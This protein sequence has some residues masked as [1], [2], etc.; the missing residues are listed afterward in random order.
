MMST[1]YN[2]T[3]STTTTYK[4]SK[5]LSTS[6]TTTMYNG[7]GTTHKIRQQLNFTDE[8][9]WKQFSSRRLELIDKFGLSE[10]KASE[11]DDNIR[12]IANMLREE[13]NYP[14]TAINEFEK[15]VTA[16]V[17]SVRRNRKRSKKRYES[18]MSNKMTKIDSG[19]SSS[20]SNSSSNSSSTASSPIQHKNVELYTSTN[21]L[22]LPSTSTSHHPLQLQQKQQH[23]TGLRSPLLS[24]HTQH[25]NNKIVSLPVATSTT[26]KNI[27]PHM[28]TPPPTITSSSA[29]SSTSTSANNT[30]SLLPPVQDQYIM[31]IRSLC[32]DLI[33]IKL[34]SINKFNTTINVNNKV[35]NFLSDKIIHKVQNSRTFISFINHNWQ[36]KAQL[37]LI[38]SSLKN[39]EVLGEM[40]TKASISFVVEKYFQDSTNNEEKFSIDFQKQ[41]SIILFNQLFNFP[42][43]A[44]YIQ[45]KFFYF[46][47]GVIVKDYGFDSTLYPLNEIIHHLI[48]NNKHPNHV[49]S[50]TQPVLPPISNGLNIL[51][52]V[53]SQ[54][55]NNNNNSYTTN[56]NNQEK[57]L[58]VN[59]LMN[60]T[61]TPSTTTAPSTTIT[62]TTTSTADSTQTTTPLP[63]LIIKESFANGTLPQPIQQIL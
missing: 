4:V 58:S 12:Q 56:N 61:N 21:Q 7:K 48:Q 47:I 60:N 59:M 8:K 14:I 31:T 32:F 45:I 62:A 19:F 49:A 20:N 35:P 15:L 46:I 3:S 10:R 11:Q 37:K 16:A 22:P 38:E 50:S 1:V 53:S 23:N 24:P 33:N 18:A 42:T 9:R 63:N 2:P 30:I 27:I 51:S 5:P 6:S 41:L 28:H 17:Q 34:Q 52:V 43:I 55:E 36:D 39:L 13:F 44:T 29:S 26:T 25:N 40:S 54:V 57:L